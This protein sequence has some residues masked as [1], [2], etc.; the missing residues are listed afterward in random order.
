[1]GH[2]LSGLSN[3]EQN[4]PDH[5]GFPQRYDTMKLLTNYLELNSLETI[6][7]YYSKQ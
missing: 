4:D 6:L 5:E 1:M 3:T 2:H 7:R